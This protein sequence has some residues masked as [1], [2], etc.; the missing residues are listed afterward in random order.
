MLS[1]PARLCAGNHQLGTAPRFEIR[2]KVF[3]FGT[4][5]RGHSR[6]ASAANMQAVLV[7]AFEMHVLQFGR[8]FIAAHRTADTFK[9]P[10][11]TAAGT[12]QTLDVCLLYT[13]D[14]AD[15]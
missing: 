10:V 3:A 1:L 8:R 11:R 7:V 4:E 12:V 15:D 6:V 13:S 5:H 9:L 2:I 14:A